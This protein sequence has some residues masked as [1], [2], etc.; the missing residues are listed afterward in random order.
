MSELPP[1]TIESVRLARIK[2]QMHVN[3]GSAGHFYLYRFPDFPRLTVAKRS[4]RPKGVVVAYLVDD[5]EVDDL[6]A[7]VVALNARPR[8]V[9][10]MSLF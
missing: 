10:Q 8:P 2:L 5:V 7:A 1:V 4:Q 9:E 3:C 6:A